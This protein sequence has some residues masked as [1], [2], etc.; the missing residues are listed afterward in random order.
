MP[1]RV[2]VVLPYGWSYS[3]SRSRSLWPRIAALPGTEVTVIA[4]EGGDRE[5]PPIPVDA[6][7]RLRRV[8]FPVWRALARV[9]LR[10]PAGE[11][12]RIAYGDSPALR[13]A[14]LDE[15]TRWRP[16]VVYVERLRALRA[17]RGIPPA[18][19]VLDPTDSE[20]LYYR[21][22]RTAKG[23]APH[24]RLVAI[25]EESRLAAFERLALPG[26]GAVIAC[27]PRDGKALT[28]TSGRE[29][30]D[31]VANGVDLTEHYPPPSAGGGG[32]DQLVMT[33]NL[34][35]LANKEA[36]GWLLSAWP[37]LRAR[38]G[39]GA[40]LTFAGGNPPA[41][42][43]AAHGQDGVRVT[44]FLPSLRDAYW[45]AGIAAVPMRLAVGTQNKLI[46]PLACGTLV[47]ATP[48][49]AAGLPDEGRAAV[50][51]AS[52]EEFPDAIAALVADPEK[53][54]V[55]RERGL[56]FTRSALD[57]DILAKQTLAILTRVATAAR[58]L[59]R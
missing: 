14:V 29:D 19:V 27:T 7:L 30:I 39:T 34:R 20:P 41:R 24:Q 9:A 43:R 44:G 17:A 12:M 59:D 13:A 28:A 47:V 48:E 50:T 57:W 2:L 46:E 1:F 21:Q 40:S 10:F 45:A 37:A 54:A 6:N 36:A 56:E 11:S 26:V 16:H 23:I 4:H 32:L 8:A 53:Q 15:Y 5:M 35:T 42:L 38:L 51:V 52:R 31:V 3:R 33:G 58:T 18:E 25:I 49:A 22:V 55:L